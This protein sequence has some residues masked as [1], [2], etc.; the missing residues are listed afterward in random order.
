MGGGRATAR[1]G[2]PFTDFGPMGVAGLFT[3][4]EAREVIGVIEEI[5]RRAV[6]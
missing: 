1:A 2:S 3:V 4:G 5:R 6:A